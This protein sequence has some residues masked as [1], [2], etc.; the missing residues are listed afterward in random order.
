MNN[1][2]SRPQRLQ[3]CINRE[4]YN[5]DLYRILS[6]SAPNEDEKKEMENFSEECR[7]TA[8]TFMQIYRSMTGY[9][10]KNEPEPVKESGSYRTVLRSR[11]RK[12]IELSKMYR[13]DYMNTNDHY[14]LKRTFFTACH[15]AL[16]RAAILGSFCQ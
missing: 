10:A 6:R 14:H 16:C 8:E 15:N 13:C 11:I 5:S 2:S 7:E 3:M 12:E 4:L 9:Q 1:F